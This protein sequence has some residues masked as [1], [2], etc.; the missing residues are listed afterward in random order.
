MKTELNDWR[1]YYADHAR[2]VKEALAPASERELK[3]LPS[4]PASVPGNFELDLVRAGLLPEDLYVGTNILEVQKWE[5]THLWYAAHVTVPETND[6]CF[7][8]FEG[9][10]TVS[11]IYVDGSLSGKTENMLVEYE[12]P[13]TPG[14]HEL[15]V[16][17][18]PARVYT[19]ALP[20]DTACRAHTYNVDSVLIRKAPYLYGWDIMPRTVTAGL[21]RPVYVV[22]K[23]KER[24]EDLF[25]LTQAL[26]TD[27]NTA[28]LA[29]RTR[30]R[31]LGCTG[32]TLH[33]CL[34]DDVQKI[35]TDVPLFSSHTLSFMRISSPA[36]WW[37]KHYG[38]AHLYSLT[39]ILQKNGR[40]LDRRT[41]RVGIR[42][43]TLERTSCAGKD[44]TFRFIV[45]G[46]P[47][48]VMGTNWVPTDAFPS[49][50][51]ALTRRGLDLVNDLSCNMIRCWGGNVYPSD[52]FYD[53][54]DEHGIL[55]WQ[56]FAMACGIYPSDDRFQALLTEEAEKLV[57]RLRSHPSLALWS[58]DNECDNSFIWVSPRMNGEKRFA[59]TPEDHVPTRV[60]LPNVLKRMD[61]FRPY[62][63]SS[64]YLDPEAFSA[65]NPS[66]NHLW[67]PRD[68]FKG[69]FY[70]KN[71]V[72]H[73]ASETGY[74]GCNAPDSLRRFLHEDHLNAHGDGKTCTDPEWLVHSSCPEPDPAAPWAYRIPL[75]TRQIERL[76]GK[77]QENIAL[78]ALQSQI[79]QAEAL[80]FFIE[81]FRI[82][83]PYRSGLLWWNIVDGWPQLSDAVVDWYGYKKLAYTY[84]RRSQAPVCL[85]MD[86][87]DENGMLTLTADN[88]TEK[89][90]QLAWRVENA[91]TGEEL[92]RGTATV[93]EHE[94]LRLAQLK[95][96]A[97]YYRLQWFGDARGENHF[98]G[99]IG[100]GITPDK[101]RAFLA[102]AGLDQKLEGF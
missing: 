26:D 57:R 88:E 89:D 56:D 25:A 53:Y 63:P 92:L 69:D 40:S 59:L 54:C 29:V 66:E 12:F 30:V 28:E 15:V 39:A 33:L 44:G 52:A 58:G 99:R 64:P 9:I 82:G 84:I 49:R 73:F 37:P 31:L 93:P 7:L 18:T 87:P 13:I 2:V 45:N 71:S 62:I 24:I 65:N 11:E 8:R 74:H 43:L 80:K 68:Y 20:L 36:L 90:V 75:M 94:N 61:P 102:A 10:D 97:L 6:D 3:S 67:G 78:F 86:E 19:D 95:E 32:Y 34:E 81:H 85:M 55:V 72:C 79:S 100:D 47:V 51:E 5:N 96:E 60:T 16:H 22:Q 4:V 42:S 101:Y 77:A 46:K 17:I 83:K 21:W 38:D 48:F 14:E 41:M 91:L 98:V 1:L 23:P 70:N 27:K 50:H 76:F 35:E